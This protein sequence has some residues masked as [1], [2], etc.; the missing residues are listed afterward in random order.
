MYRLL[1]IFVMLLFF[2]AC[3]FHAEEPEEKQVHIDSAFQYLEIHDVFDI[4]LVEDTVNKVVFSAEKHL[5]HK[6]QAERENDT[7]MLKNQSSLKWINDLEHKQVAL[8]FTSL[9]Q[10]TIHA[11]AYLYNSDT[12]HF[13]S[14]KIVC[15]SQM[16]D[17]DLLVDAGRLYFVNSDT[18]GGNFSFSGKADNLVIFQRGTASVN[19]FSLKARKARVKLNS[20]RDCRLHAEKQLRVTIDRPS[21]VYY[22]GKPEI[23]SRDIG[24]GGKLIPVNEE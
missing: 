12:L 9:K 17:I 18:G 24:E 11:P 2:Q 14:L 15:F 3:S 8:H 1:T 4:E 10:I 21:N 6:L 5:L 19:A 23:V 20:Y 22:S 13:H 16:G 7:L